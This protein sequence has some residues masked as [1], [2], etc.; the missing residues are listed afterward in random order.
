[1]KGKQKKSI[2][3]EV[4]CVNEAMFQRD[5]FRSWSFQYEHLEQFRPA[6]PQAFER[7]ENE[8]GIGITLH[9]ELPRSLRTDGALVP[10][11]WRVE[12]RDSECQDLPLCWIVESDCPNSSAQK[13]LSPEGTADTGSSYLLTPVQ[14]EAF[15]NSRDPLRADGDF[16]RRER[17]IICNLGAIFCEETWEERSDVP[18][19]LTAQAPGNP[20]FSQFVPHC[21]NIFSLSFLPQKEKAVYDIT[22]TGWYSVPPEGQPDLVCEGCIEGVTWDLQ[23]ELP[24]MDPLQKLADSGDLNVSVGNS[25]YEALMAMLEQMLPEQ[26][27]LIKTLEAALLNCT[28]TLEAADGLFR[29]R[30]KAREMSFHGKHGGIQYVRQEESLT[31]SAKERS[32][33][34]WKQVIFQKNQQQAELEEE[35]RKLGGLQQEL[36]DLWWKH[37]RFLH[38][39]LNNFEHLR[40]EFAFSLDG[41]RPDSLLSR[42]IDQYEKVKIL[43]KRISAENS[44]LKAVPTKTFYQAGNPV[45]LFLGIQPPGALAYEDWEE[46][47]PQKYEVSWEPM[48]LEWRVGYVHVPFEKE[49]WKLTLQGYQLR[50]EAF[51]EE[52]EEYE[53][54]ALLG[55]QTQENL[56]ER[57]SDIWRGEG[58]EQQFS[59]IRNRPLLT[60]EL[61]G[62]QEKLA[63]REV[64]AFTGP[65]EETVNWKGKSYLLT[66]LLEGGVETAPALDGDKQ[67]PFYET[68][69]G[70]LV[71]KDLILYDK[72]GRIFNVV[73]SESH[74]G[75]Q[76]GRAFLALPSKDMCPERALYPG[77]AYPLELKPKL[78]LPARLDAKLKQIEGMMFINELDHSLE[79]F[80]GDG[81][82][83]GQL[84][85]DCSNGQVEWEMGPGCEAAV[86]WEDAEKISPTIMAWADSWRK[87][88]KEKL[89]E[90][91]DLLEERLCTGKLSGDQEGIW[92]YFSR[93]IL[94][95]KAEFSCVLERNPYQHQDWNTVVHPQSNTLEKTAVPFLIGNGFDPGDGLVGCFRKEN[96]EC[97]YQPGEDIGVALKPAVSGETLELLL[98]FDPSR[99]VHIYTD[100][101]PDAK[102]YLGDE[103]KELLSKAGQYLS[104]SPLLSWKKEGRLA[105]PPIA[106]IE[107]FYFQ[108]TEY[109]SDRWELAAEQGCGRTETEEMEAFEGYL[110]R[111]GEH[112]GVDG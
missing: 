79:L 74:F 93:P 59:D 46:E 19:F 9:W 25:S 5:E 97:M 47:G 73:R 58:L 35:E 29:R 103:E 10:N 43:K 50:D 99:P 49:N 2:K 112:Y 15:L 31:Y 54:M 1:M 62:F 18:L 69:S 68:R 11:R 70:Q 95:A 87:G 56:A 80:S 60:V 63:Q 23:G 45:L 17:G 12:I 4:L 53:G 105:F 51:C 52:M 22:V 102:I 72:F 41:E 78:L 21:R 109:S 90:F 66:E 83:L 16:V 82:S 34:A 57:L 76:L 37:G 65:G 8:L 36:F 107:N 77:M 61:T 101:L 20:V 44:G 89:Q 3:L 64:R 86:S 85:V 40:K 88:R 27:E 28:D 91:L 98:L 110:I 30:E 39:S 14:L 84:Y 26:E 13:K 100:L 7:Q 33:E 24:D 55:R 75:R 104:V 71:L 94:L 32:M 42:T 111:K 81:R 108:A 48:Y 67:Y 96:L 92:M 38:S 6:E 106:G